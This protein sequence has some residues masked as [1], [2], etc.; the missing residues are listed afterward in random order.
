MTLSVCM[1]AHNEEEKIGEALESVR[2]ANE[3][4]V[5]DCGSQDETA[6]I[7]RAFHVRLFSRPN[8]ANLNVNKNFTF[9]QAT[10]DWILCLDADEVVPPET[11]REIQDLLRHPPR[12]A[13]F[14]LPRRNYYFGHW[15]KYGGRYPDWQL[16]LFRRGQGR[17]PARHIHERLQLDGSVGRLRH[18]LDHYPYQ[19]R[20]ECQ[21]KLE[22][23][24]SF[25]ALHLYNQGIRPSALNSFKYK[26]W[27]PVRRFLNR[28]L[29]KGGFLD[30]WAGWQ[31]ILMD[32]RNYR[33]RY[34]KLKELMHRSPERSTP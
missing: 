29:L 10:S 12:E 20:D 23:Y 28:Y 5:A 32:M 19:T 6:L 15:M 9:D 2:F 18:P 7:A 26:F 11:A 13:G 34:A 30:G 1:I 33:L 4:I 25:E 24:T 16:R 22:L 17:F 8:L 3:I 21:R 14:Y 27:L 31:A